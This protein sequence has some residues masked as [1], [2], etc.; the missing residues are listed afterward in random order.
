MEG[1]GGRLRG[2]GCGSGG[3]NSGCK[4]CDFSFLLFLWRSG[5]SKSPEIARL[6]YC[7]PREDAAP[8]D[9]DPCVAPSAA[10]GTESG[11][12]LPTGIDTAAVGGGA[13]A[14]NF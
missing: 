7:Q 2:V 1:G 14:D 6:P 9:A 4:K 8:C 10:P 13:N 3:D 11:G 5:L 12:V